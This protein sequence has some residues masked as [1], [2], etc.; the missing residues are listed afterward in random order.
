VLGERDRGVLRPGVRVADQFTRHDR[1]T[2]AAALPQCHPQRD[3]DELDGLGGVDGSRHGPLR[4]GTEAEGN[5]DDPAH[6]RA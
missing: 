1:M 4:E 5:V 6:V 2:L 3:V